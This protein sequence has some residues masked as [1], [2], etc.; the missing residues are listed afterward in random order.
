M[1]SSQVE[2]GRDNQLLPAGVASFVKSHIGG[3]FNA[4]PVSG[5][6]K[7][8]VY[9]VTQLDLTCYLKVRGP[10]LSGIPSLQQNPEDIRFEK[11]AL[12]ICAEALPDVFPH[13][14]GY[15][16]EFS[17][18]LITDVLPDGTTLENAFN[19]GLVGPEQMVSIGETLGRTHVA[20]QNSKPIR[21]DG[22]SVQYERNLKHRITRFDVLGK[23]G[24]SSQLR[25]L[26]HR[27]LILGDLCPKNI[28]LRA[29]GKVSF[30]DLDHM[31]WGNP[32]FDLGFFMAHLPL[33][34]ANPSMVPD[35]MAKAVADGYARY[36]PTLDTGGILQKKISAATILYRLKNDHIPY[37]SPLQAQQRAN[38]IQEAQA[39]LNPVASGTVWTLET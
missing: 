32:E 23:D 7:H 4:Q 28:G 6:Y 25:Q 16:D 1:S 26:P 34:S 22:D 36:N 11:K 13:V 27:Q 39:I 38:L 21:E 14:M 29:N 8:Q 18:L 33:H 17:A 19:A 12:E 10:T 5:G 2:S 31:H 15:S 20:L 30:F 9:K 3:G 37:E 35:S 24:L